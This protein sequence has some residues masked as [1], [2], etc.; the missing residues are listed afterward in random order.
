MGARHGHCWLSQKDKFRLRKLLRISYLEHKTNEFV[1]NKAESL[2]GPQEPLLATMKRRKLKWFGHVTRHNSLCQTIMQGT[3]EGGR[4]R[5]RQRK[6]WVDN[7]KEWTNM[8]MSELLVQAAD[9]TAWRR[10]LASSAP[11]SPQR[12]QQ[13]RET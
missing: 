7:V 2:V 9:R 11:G 10:T 5:G 8:N 3:V 13:S 6:S 4:R 12:R 1:R